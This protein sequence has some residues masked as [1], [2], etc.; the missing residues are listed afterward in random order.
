ML[1]LKAG[2]AGN[3]V[4]LWYTVTFSK[5]KSVLNRAKSMDKPDLADQCN[6]HVEL[7]MIIC[8]SEVDCN[9]GVH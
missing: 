5:Y 8:C 3:N 1:I 4:I 7:Y 9:S 2:N 6:A